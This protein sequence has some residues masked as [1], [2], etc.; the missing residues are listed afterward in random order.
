MG[1]ERRIASYGTKAAWDMTPRQYRRYLHK[2]FR[3]GESTIGYVTHKGRP[4]PR[5]RRSRAAS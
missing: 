3:S 4:T 2:K 5:Q 1:S